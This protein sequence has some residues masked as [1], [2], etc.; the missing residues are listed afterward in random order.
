MQLIQLTMRGVQV[1]SKEVHAGMYI[2]AILPAG[3]ASEVRERSQDLR[4]E[5]RDE[6]S[7]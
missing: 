6:A 4:S 2:R 3:R 5:Q 7:E 1:S